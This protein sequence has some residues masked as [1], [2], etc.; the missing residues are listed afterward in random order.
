MPHSKDEDIETRAIEMARDDK[1]EWV[2]RPSRPDQPD[3]P[4]GATNA[5]RDAY[6]QKARE[7]IDNELP[8][9]S[10]TS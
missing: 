6:R 1:L 9:A 5:E 8:K 7:Q 4:A 10:G 2:K 3:T